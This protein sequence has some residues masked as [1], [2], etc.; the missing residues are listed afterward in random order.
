M[1]DFE[2]ASLSIGPHS[3]SDTTIFRTK[4]GAF[5]GDNAEYSGVV[6]LDNERPYMRLQSD[7][8]NDDGFEINFGDFVFLE[9]HYKIDINM[10]TGMVIKHT[11][12]ILEKRSLI[13]LNP[14]DTWKKVY[15]N[16]TPIVND[17][18]GAVN[19]RVFF[20]ATKTSSNPETI[21]MMLDNIKLIATQSK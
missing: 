11:N 13:G 20:E 2:D 12:D 19:F 4:D 15:I 1:E 17:N 6:F 7:D 14:T 8:G 16:M 5:M 9:L 3:N 21:E 10:E 18:P